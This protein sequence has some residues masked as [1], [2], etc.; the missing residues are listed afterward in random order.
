MRS[1][2]S[3]PD[4]RSCWSLQGPG[5][6]MEWLLWG[7][8]LVL[9]NAAH[10]WTKRASGSASLGYHAAACVVANGIW[11]I[12]QLFI[13]DTLLKVVESKNLLLLW[14][15]GIF[16]VTCTVAGSVGMHWAL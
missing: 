2:A 14:T 8:V 12:S 15:T 3:R 9:Q 1:E 4:G 11:F 16:Y 5:I 7:I 10:T 13:L 6:E